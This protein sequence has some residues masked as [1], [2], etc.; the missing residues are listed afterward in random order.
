MKKLLSIIFTLTFLTALAQDSTKSQ[1]APKDT[2]WKTSGMFGLNFSST[3]LNNWAAGGENNIALNSL[4]NYQTIYQKQNVIWESKLD[5]QFGVVKNNNATNFKKNL[6]Q[7]LFLTKYN[8]KTHTKHWYY[9]AQADYRSQFAPAYVYNGNERDTSKR[10]TSDLNSP[11]YIQ[12]AF[13]LDYKPN[14]FLSVNFAPLAGKITRVNRQYLA[15]EG[16]FGVKPAERN[17]QGEITK[18]GEKTRYEFGGR[19]VVKFK[20]EIVKNAT[21]DSYLDLFSA[22]DKHFGNI[23]VTFN[24]LLAIKLNK[25][26]ALTVLCQMLYDD[27]VTIKR[28]WDN[29]GKYDKPEDIYGPRLQVLSSFALGLNIKL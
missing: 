24:N 10:A 6:D 15:D 9:S 13:G 3:A 18:H 1:T 22:Y 25:Y 20:K 23:D 8:Y 2:S 19:I 5:A 7:I 17:A 27:D 21:L 11:G 14:S 28:D 26:F 4:I 16:A 12:L 29:D